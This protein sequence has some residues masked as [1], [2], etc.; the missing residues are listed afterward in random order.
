MIKIIFLILIALTISLNTFSQDDDVKPIKENK[1]ERTLLQRII[2]DLGATPYQYNTNNRGYT[3]SFNFALG[4]EFNKLDVRLNFDLNSRFYESAI[5]WC[6]FGGF[7]YEQT[8][9]KFSNLSLGLGYSIF[10]DIK[11]IN[12]TTDIDLQAKIGY[13]IYSNDWQAAFYDMFLR[14]KFNDLVYVGTGINLNSS[15]L[16]REYV[17]FYVKFGIEI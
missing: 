3:Q 17:G 16:T 2:I 11:F 12:Y 8:K 6:G 1:N 7:E 9:D 15:V 13:S 4:Y 10:N 14:A 5:G